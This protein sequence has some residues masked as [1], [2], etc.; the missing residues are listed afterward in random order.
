LFRL[1]CPP[2][3][4]TSFLSLAFQIP[5]LNARFMRLICITNDLPCDSRHDNLTLII[6]LCPYKIL[7]KQKKNI[8][9]L[10]SFFGWVVRVHDVYP[11]KS[12]FFYFALLS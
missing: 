9:T 8:G 12:F 3:S 11:L 5:C 7:A 6:V 1:S 4:V 10:S 2:F